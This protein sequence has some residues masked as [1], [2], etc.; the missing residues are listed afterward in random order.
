M[1]WGQACGLQVAIAMAVSASSVGVSVRRRRYALAP[2]KDPW[3]MFQ[4]NA[5]YLRPSKRPGVSVSFLIGIEIGRRRTT[6]GNDRLGSLDESREPLL[7]T[8]R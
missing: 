8:L 3:G 2:C 7:R 4:G 1:S 5:I 6:R